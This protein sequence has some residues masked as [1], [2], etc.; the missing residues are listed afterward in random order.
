MDMGLDAPESSS[1]PGDELLP[2]DPDDPD[3]VKVTDVVV[4]TLPCPSLPPKFQ[5]P[6]PTRAGRG[7]N[8]A[9][10][11]RGPAG[12]SLGPPAWP[13]LGFQPAH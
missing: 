10:K 7:L 11:A 12:L 9:R 13:G 5:F 1:K 8:P 3:K 6:I 4:E 2:D